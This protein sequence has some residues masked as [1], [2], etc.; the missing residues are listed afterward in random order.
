MFYKRQPHG[1][2]LNEQM[3]AKLNLTANN[4]T[5]SL[6]TEVFDQNSFAVIQRKMWEESMPNTML[7]LCLF[8]FKY[9]KSGKYFVC[10]VSISC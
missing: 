9:I 10:N 6:R 3:W 7:H 4:I 5:T 2:I 8:A 1:E